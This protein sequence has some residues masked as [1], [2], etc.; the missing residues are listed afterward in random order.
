MRKMK[1]QNLKMIKLQSFFSKKI[2]EESEESHKPT[3]SELAAEESRR[4]REELLNKAREKV[5]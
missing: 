1:T 5:R 4:R 3:A 2:F